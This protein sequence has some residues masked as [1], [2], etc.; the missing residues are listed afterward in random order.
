MRNLRTL[1]EGHKCNIHLNTQLKQTKDCNL[2][3]NL[4]TKHKQLLSLIS[5]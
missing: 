2:L 3:D 4:K 5:I 1:R